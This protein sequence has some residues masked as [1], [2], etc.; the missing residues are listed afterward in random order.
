MVDTPKILAQA[1]VSAFSPTALQSLCRQLGQADFALICLFLAPSLRDSQLPK[2]LSDRFPDTEIIGCKTAG[3]LGA[4]GYE[5][6]QIIAIGFPTSH[7]AATVEQVDDLTQIHERDLV[8]RLVTQRVNLQ[9]QAPKM[10]SEFGFLLVDGLS[11]KED[12]L[13]SVLASALGP[14]PLFGGSSGDGVDFQS[15]YLFRNGEKIE[16]GALLA[17]IRSFCPVQVFSLDNLTPGD[18]RMVVTKASP[19]ERIVHEINAEPAG[20]EYARLLGLDPNQLDQFTFSAHPVVV[21]VGDSHHVRAIQ[22]VA[23]NS[24]LH[25]FSTIDEGMVLSLALQDDLPSHLEQGLQALCETTQPAAIL[26]C[27]C[28]LRRMDAHQ[29]QKTRQ[30]SEVLKKFQVFGFSTY[31][32]QIGGLHVNQTLTGVAFYPPEDSPACP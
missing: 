2:Q 10:K 17:L 13:V 29:M 16:N 11:R 20:L 22:Q 26:G 4:E 14:L 3:E 5:E 24:D 9:G 23:G 25:F 8:T 30:V 12:Y 15:T 27:D 21:R 7:F 28:L 18:T 1:Q 6:D 31:G 19:E 32:E